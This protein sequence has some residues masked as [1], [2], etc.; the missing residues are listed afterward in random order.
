MEQKEKEFLARQLRIAQ[1][2]Q[3]EF[4]RFK[5]NTR[6]Q[7]LSNQQQYFQSLGGIGL[8]VIS[9]LF[10]TQIIT[11]SVWWFLA[12]L[13]GLVLVAYVSTHVRELNDNEAKGLNKEE[14]AMTQKYEQIEAKVLEAWK[15]DDPSIYSSYLMQ[16]APIEGENPEISYAGEIA[17]F[18]FLL[19][20]F[21][22]MLAFLVAKVSLS[23]LPLSL[24]VF[25]GII[26]C[27]ALAMGDWNLKITGKVSR[28]IHRILKKGI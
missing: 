19:M 7:L 9:I 13:T 24:V 15:S 8:A 4:F 27:F 3:D 6:I 10:A 17:V 25:G 1:E 22:S 26:L 23:C 12:G 11:V 21:W 2:W 5:Q 20:V 14:E 18:L 16:K 28:L